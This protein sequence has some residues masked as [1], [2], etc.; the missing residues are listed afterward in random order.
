MLE[1][2][3]YEPAPNPIPLCVRVTHGWVCMHKTQ[4]LTHTQTAFTKGIA[5][6]FTKPSTQA[7]TVQRGYDP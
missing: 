4:G 6:V 1:S 2:C 5:A 7:Y 3:I